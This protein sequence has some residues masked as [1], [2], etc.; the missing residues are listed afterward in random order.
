MPLN[1]Y[2]MSVNKC[3]NINFKSK[4]LKRKNIKK[5]TEMYMVDEAHLT[6]L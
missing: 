1:I 6:D 4:K 5:I 2:Y 3:I